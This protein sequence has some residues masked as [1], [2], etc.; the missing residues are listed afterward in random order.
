MSVWSSGRSSSRANVAALEEDRSRGLPVRARRHEHEGR[1]DPV[2]VAGTSR[3]R[4]R[5]PRGGGAAPR[6]IVAF[7]SG[8]EHAVPEAA[9]RVHHG[10]RGVDRVD[11]VGLGAARGRVRAD[12]DRAAPG[13]SSR[14]DRSPS[15][16]RRRS[17]RRA[18][19]RSGG[20]TGRRRGRRSGRRAASTLPVG[21]HAD[22]AGA[23]AG[24]PR[25]TRTSSVPTPAPA[26]IASTT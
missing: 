22:Q 25:P 4:A 7:P 21:S 20:G 6:A 3:A 8:I 23:G 17:P 26:T 15:A 24:L 16:G 14:L 9:E 19:S 13:S 2:E 12:G 1:V 11:V 10:A 5:A 18:P